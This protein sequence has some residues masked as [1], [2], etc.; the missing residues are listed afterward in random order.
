[1]TQFEVRMSPNVTSQ[2]GREID[3]LLDNDAN[4]DDDDD[5]FHHVTGGRKGRYECKVICTMTKHL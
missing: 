4:D 5:A 1:M 3:T 2:W